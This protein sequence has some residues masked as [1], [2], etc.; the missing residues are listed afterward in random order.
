MTD[1]SDRRPR[2][3]KFVWF[4][5]ASH[6]AK[7][8][9]AFYAELLGWKASSWDDSGYDMI[10]TGNTIDTMIGAYTAMRGDR[11]ASHWVSYVSVED[12]D[13]TA[14]AVAAHGGNVI[15]PPHDLPD[16]GRAAG[17]T[18]PQGAELWLFKNAEGDLA[19]PP[20][21]EPPP[22]R[23][24]FWCELHTT[25]PLGAVSFYEKVLGYT[26]ETMDMGPGGAYHIL[27]RDGVGRAGVTGH[28][29][30]AAPHWLPYVAVDDPDAI[31]ARAK[32]LGAKILV[33]LENI[34]GVGRFGV[35][36]DPTGAVLAVMKALP[37]SQGG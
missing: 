7:K 31:I 23:R 11:R 4:E 20:L 29:Q 12:V 6:D 1:A 26:R 34:P 37:P 2:P 24:F 10:L 14:K 13:A 16:V 25:D 22:A 27:N 15:E 3:G 9:Q 21:T 32:K 17:I 33:G 28:L 35:L 18:D 30:G 36:E 8:A 5:H 19:D